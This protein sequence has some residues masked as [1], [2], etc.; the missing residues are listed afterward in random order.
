MFL[1]VG[2]EEVVRPSD[3]TGTA[4]AGAGSKLV[5]TIG[6]S[7]SAA[8]L[9]A[10]KTVTPACGTIRASWPAMPWQAGLT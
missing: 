4:R 9:T 1:D 2:M 8:A 5:I 6:P 10:G 7:V 3:D